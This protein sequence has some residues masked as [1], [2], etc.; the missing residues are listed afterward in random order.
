MNRSAEQIVTD[1]L[2]GKKV[3]FYIEAR[4]IGGEISRK[5]ETDD[6]SKGWKVRKTDSGS[7]KF[8]NEKVVDK[9]VRVRRVGY[10]WI[11]DTLEGYYL[12]RKSDGKIN[13]LD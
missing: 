12:Q 11:Y 6:D 4:L 9:I 1:F 10:D 7:Y 2:I 3:E 5:H 8:R 13:I